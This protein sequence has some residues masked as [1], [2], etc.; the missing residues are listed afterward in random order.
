MTSSDSRDKGTKAAEKA[1][2]NAAKRSHYRYFYKVYNVG[3]YPA[4]SLAEINARSLAGWRVHTVNLNYSEVAIFWELDAETEP[5][6]D[7]DPEQE[8]LAAA[9]PA[10]TGVGF[11]VEPT[12][13][14]GSMGLGSEQPEDPETPDNPDQ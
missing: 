13:Q 10:G 7:G 8:F 6:T 12:A 9:G 14:T 4:E 1:A 2:A 3:Q 11:G 5:D